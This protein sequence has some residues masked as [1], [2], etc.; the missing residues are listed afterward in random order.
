MAGLRF[1]V[2][3]I[4]EIEAGRLTR[5]EQHPE[6]ANHA[7][8]LLLARIIGIGIQTADMLVHE[9]LSRHLHYRNAVARYGGLTGA[10]DESGAHGPFSPRA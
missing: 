5:L 3:Q 9:I 7:M 10:P 2:E 6:Q 4:R 8:I 1:I